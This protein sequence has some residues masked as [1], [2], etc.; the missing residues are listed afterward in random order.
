MV[1]LDDFNSPRLW[2]EPLGPSI[3]DTFFMEQNQKET[4][5]TTQVSNEDAAESH[6]CCLLGLP[7]PS[8]GRWW[9]GFL[10]KNVN[11][12][13]SCNFSGCS[14]WENVEHDG[15]QWKWIWQCNWWHCSS[16]TFNG[17]KGV[18]ESRSF[19][20]WR[21]A[22]LFFVEVWILQLDFSWRQPFPESVWGDR[23]AQAWRWFE[24]LQPWGAGPCNEALCCADLLFEGKMCCFGEELFSSQ[25]WFSFVE[26]LAGWVWTSKPTV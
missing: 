26:R 19:H 18:E 25:R 24:T 9:A 15:K 23:E 21:P 11:F 8:Y 5:W 4:M 7:Q 6:S 3:E 13:R 16:R 2:C 10:A 17:L 12:G 1:Q 20:R 14:G 22:F